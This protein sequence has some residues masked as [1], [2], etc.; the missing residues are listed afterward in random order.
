MRPALDKRL[1]RLRAG[2]AQPARAREE[3]RREALRARVA[4]G[5]RLREMLVARGVDPAQVAA[6][7]PI[8]E[9]AAEL[10][11]L[12]GGGAEAKR[13]PKEPDEQTAELWAA[14]RGGG[15]ADGFIRE[16]VRLALLHYADGQR[17]DPARDS[18][19]QWQ[20]WCLVTPASPG[21][22]SI[23]VDPE[24]ARYREMLQRETGAPP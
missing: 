11:A 22:P 2:V 23:L 8:E 1:K 4:I 13:A 18:L 9:A 20:A 24:V 14:A 12:P 5:G 10:A 17:P 3:A 6:L 15:G 16:L 21:E 19:M 7:R